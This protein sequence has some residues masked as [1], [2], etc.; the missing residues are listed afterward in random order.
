[1]IWETDATV[2]DQGF[3]PLDA[4]AGDWVSWPVPD[5]GEIGVGNQL[6]QTISPNPDFYNGVWIFGR[7]PKYPVMLTGYTHDIYGAAADLLREWA[8]LT[9]LDFDV[10]ADGTALKRSQK[11]AMLNLQADNYSA[12]ARARS[13]DLIRTDETQDP[14]LTYDDGYPDSRVNP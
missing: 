1:M 13:S 10:S 14:H 12:K 9:A 11:S 2:V 3:N 8:V 5:L 4:V 6:D 7:Q